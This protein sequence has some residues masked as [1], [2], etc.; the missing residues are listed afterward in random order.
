M[1]N[2]RI[3]KIVS[4][5]DGKCWCKGIIEDEIKQLY[6]EIEDISIESYLPK[7]WSWWCGTIP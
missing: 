6:S 4:D 1:K 2:Y 7:M 3:L 5:G